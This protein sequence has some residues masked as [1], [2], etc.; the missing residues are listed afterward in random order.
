VIDRLSEQIAS[1]LEKPL[2]RLLTSPTLEEIREVLE[3]VGPHHRILISLPGEGMTD[4][5]LQA[6][7]KRFPHVTF[8]LLLGDEEPRLRQETIEL[9]FP[10]LAQGEEDKLSSQYKKSRNILLFG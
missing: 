8:F 4:E 7:R 10:E 9:L 3:D 5:V 6:L 1:A 2:K